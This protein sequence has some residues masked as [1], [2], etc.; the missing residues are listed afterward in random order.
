VVDPPHQ[1]QIE[2]HNHLDEANARFR[3]VIRRIFSFARG[4]LLGAIPGLPFKQQPMAVR[5]RPQELAFL[6]RDGALYPVDA[7]PEFPFQELSPI[8]ITRC[9]AAND[10]T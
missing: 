1:E 3:R 8:S 9:P 5:E 7:L 4:L 10:R 2:F 6:N